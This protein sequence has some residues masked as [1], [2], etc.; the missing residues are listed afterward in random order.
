MTSG[1]AR[2]ES[3]KMQRYYTLEN[4]VPPPLSNV[5][6]QSTEQHPVGAEK[7]HWF[8]HANPT[9]LECCTQ[10]LIVVFI[11]RTVS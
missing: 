3:N 9:V 11:G 4:G 1:T 7:H 2:A 8:K 10:Q 6:I 5:K